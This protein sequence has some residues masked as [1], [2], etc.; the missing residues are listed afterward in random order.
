[1]KTVDPVEAV[2]AKL[3][4]AEKAMTAPWRNGADAMG[5]MKTWDNL[6]ALRNAVPALLAI[7]RAAAAI[8]GHSGGCSLRPCDC[9][10][11]SVAVA[12][13]ALVAAMQSPKE[14]Q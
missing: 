13:G 12:L 8:D 3:E 9:G 2:I 10:F 6:I 5:G 1:M 11:G 14:E 4:A 7:A